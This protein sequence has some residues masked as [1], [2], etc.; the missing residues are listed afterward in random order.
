MTIVTLVSLMAIKMGFS[1]YS[2]RI[3]IREVYNGD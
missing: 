3:K 2:H 1:V